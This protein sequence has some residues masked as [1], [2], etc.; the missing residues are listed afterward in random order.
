MILFLLNCS[1][2]RMTF[3]V[4][5]TIKYPPGSRGHSFN[6]VISEGV[7]LANTHF[8]LRSMIGILPIDTPFRVTRV[9]AVLPSAR[10]SH[11]YRFSRVLSRNS[12][13]FRSYSLQRRHR[14]VRLAV[15]Q[16]RSGSSYADHAH[17]W[18]FISRSCF[19]YEQ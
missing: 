13:G 4:P 11:R 16:E 15:A 1:W 6:T 12:P 8:E 5:L 2:T 14:P 3:S 7:L 19:I 9:E 10:R 17:R 18:Q